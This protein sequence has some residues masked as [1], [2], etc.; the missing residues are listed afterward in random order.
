MVHKGS[1][2]INIYT[3]QDV[4]GIEMRQMCP[5]SYNIV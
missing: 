3:P 2:V 4:G 1:R 5:V